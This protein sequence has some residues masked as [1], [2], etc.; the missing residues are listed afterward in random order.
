VGDSEWVQEGGRNKGVAALINKSQGSGEGQAQAKARQQKNCDGRR[1][2]GRYPERELSRL[3]N[4]VFAIGLR[5]TNSISCFEHIH[6]E[7]G[8]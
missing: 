7:D 6:E 8:R 3:R 1:K 2:P 4:G 5:P